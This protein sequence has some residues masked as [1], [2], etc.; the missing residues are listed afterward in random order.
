MLIMETCRELPVLPTLSVNS[1]LETKKK[2]KKIKKVFIV[3]VL[4][5]GSNTVAYFMEKFMVSLTFRVTL[6]HNV[7]VEPRE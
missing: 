6:T 2:S 3:S 1:L 4:I 7:L 5:P